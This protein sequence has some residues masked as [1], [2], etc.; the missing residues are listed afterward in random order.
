[1][2]VIVKQGFKR[3]SVIF[4]MTSRITSLSTAWYVLESPLPPMALMTASAFPMAVAKELQTGQH[5]SL[6]FGMLSEGTAAM[7]PY[8]STA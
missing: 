5:P 3:H 4:V 8:S 6:T 1:M 2:S 7:A